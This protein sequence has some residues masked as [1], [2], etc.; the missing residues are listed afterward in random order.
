[1]GASLY[2]NAA[3]GAIA[4]T[5]AAVIAAWV[6]RRGQ[7]VNESVEITK[8]QMQTWK[9]LLAQKNADIEDLE[10]KV[11]ERDAVITALSK[12]NE[13]LHEQHKAMKEPP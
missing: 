9:D 13:L 5:V 2:A 7:V 12:H 3:I 10:A 8:L 1:V 6:N 4:A 11:A